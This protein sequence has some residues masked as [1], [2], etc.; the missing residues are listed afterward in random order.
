MELKLLVSSNPRYFGKIRSVP[1][2][3]VQCTL[4]MYTKNHDFSTFTFLGKLISVLRSRSRIFLA[5]AG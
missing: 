3:V 5:G 4:S 1:D 2:L